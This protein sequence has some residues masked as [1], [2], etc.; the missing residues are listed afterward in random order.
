MNKEWSG[1][2]SAS[3]ELLLGQQ[4]GL[5]IPHTSVS[6]PPSQHREPVWVSRTRLGRSNIKEHMSSSCISDTGG[7]TCSPAVHAAPS[8]RLLLSQPT[9]HSLFQSPEGTTVISNP[10]IMSSQKPEEGLFY[11]LWGHTPASQ[12]RATNPLILRGASNTGNQRSHIGLPWSQL[13]SHQRRRF[14]SASGLKGCGCE[15][16]DGPLWPGVDVTA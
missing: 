8:A 11:L 9:N 1:I 5:G 4:C 2:I 6:H 12:A 7:G 14:G 13:G 16:C 15:V 3:R 10:S